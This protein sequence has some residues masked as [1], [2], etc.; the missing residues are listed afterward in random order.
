MI[1]ETFEIRE[2]TV[3]FY[4]KIRLL[5]IYIHNLTA[6]NYENNQSG[7]FCQWLRNAI[8]NF[9]FTKEIRI[10]IFFVLTSYVIFIFCSDLCHLLSNTSSKIFLNTVMKV[11][12]VKMKRVFRILIVHRWS[13][14]SLLL[15]QRCYQSATPLFFVQIGFRVFAQY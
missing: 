10:I 9:L 13:L 1:Y 5:Y 6:T 7:R 12:Y 4:Y 11:D 8:N 14:V 2:L 3:I 15:N